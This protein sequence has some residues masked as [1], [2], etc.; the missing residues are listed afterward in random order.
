MTDEIIK[1]LDRVPVFHGLPRSQLQAL[2]G[3]AVPL[4]YQPGDTIFMEGDPAEGFFLILSGQVKVYKLSLDGKEQVL[5]FVGPDEIFAEVPVFSSGD[6]PAHAGALRETRTL[7]FPRLA[8]RRLLANDPTLA[9]NMLADLSRRLR[10]LTKLVENL[11]LKESPARLAAYLLHMSTEL[12]QADEVELDVSKGQLATLL[13][14]T[15]E[16]LSRTLKKLSENGIIEVQ[17]RTIR[18]LDKA[19][20]ERMAD[21]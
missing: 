2:A 11:S 17:T 6:Y 21:G 5:H 16:T 10:Q 1:H 18:L 15:P 13:G 14:T 19:A 12:R 7:F 8:M 3:I 20:L 9:M 4:A